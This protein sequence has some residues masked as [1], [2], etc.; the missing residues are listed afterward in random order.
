MKIECVQTILEYALNKSA[1][2]TDKNPSFPILSCI[3]LEAVNHALII[4]ATN[5]DL[6][7]EIHL[8]VKVEK[9][10]KIAVSGYILAQYLT[11]ISPGKNIILEQNNENLLVR[12][13][14][15][16]TTL[17]GIS[18]EDFPVIPR[19]LKEN[20]YTAQSEDFMKGIKS[21]F[22]SAASSRIKPELASVYI[23]C[24][25]NTIFFV[26]T[27]AFRLA[28][29]KLI[30]KNTSDF[31]PLLI[32]IKNVVD[33]MRT[34]EDITSPLTLSWNEHQMGI[35]F[36]NTYLT[37]RLVSGNFPDYAMIVPKEHTTE[38]VA[39]KNDVLRALKTATI[40]SD[41]SNQSKLFMSSQ[42]KKLDIVTKNADIGENSESIDA[43]VEGEV[44]EVTV[45]YRFLLDCFQS[46]TSDS[47]VM[48]FSGP[49]KPII[50]KGAGDQSFTYLIMPINT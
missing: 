15:S 33:I 1:R 26:A 37:S 35:E 2:F 28:E 41:K 19:I 27:D 14:K 44:L 43:V 39:L 20:S 11:S 36:E 4:R 22:Y 47:M 8:P 34:L 9:E 32:P 48:Q 17:K 50:I 5:L 29:K 49:H 46:L 23:A 6:G 40:F 45:N 10:G 18:H 24:F 7:I 38:V 30:S 12:S 16:R 42:N 13:N 31:G 21:V 25:H 3:L